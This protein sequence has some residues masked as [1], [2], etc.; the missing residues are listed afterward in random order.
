MKILSA[1]Q[2]READAYT[3]AHEP[4]A[5][6]DLMERASK[7]FTEWFVELFDDT[8]SICVIAGKGN[9]GG[10]G[11]A[12]ARLL[13]DNG[14]EVKASV[15]GEGEGSEDFEIN[16]QRLSRELE[17]PRI[18]SVDELN[19]LLECD[20]IIDGIFGSGLTRPVEGLHAEVIEQINHS[21]AVRVAIDIS[22][23]LFSDRSSLGNTAVRVDFTFSFQLPKLAP[24]LP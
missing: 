5:S 14:Y 21:D 23:G 7:A 12:I 13:L 6:V 2:I 24:I 10:D 8:H 11:L 20:V 19:G 18:T 4:V 22:S 1:E 17:V 3:I 16:L 15:I 9:N